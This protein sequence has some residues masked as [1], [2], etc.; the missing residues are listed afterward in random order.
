MKR[1]APYL[2]A[3]VLAIVAVV[4]IAIALIRGARADRCAAEL[5]EHRSDRAY[6]SQAIKS[7]TLPDELIKAHSVEVGFV[8]PYEADTARVG[9]F[10]RATS[11]STRSG[12]IVLT[13]E[14]GEND[15]CVFMRDYESGAFAQ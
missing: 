14:R 15:A 9:L 12:L 6:L 2:V 11:T 4:F 10:L 1:A 13:L 3:G 7:P 5:V 8:R